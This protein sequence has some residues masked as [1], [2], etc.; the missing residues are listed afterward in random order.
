MP[1]Q[2]RNL[3]IYARKRHGYS[4]PPNATIRY[5][6]AA[7]DEFPSDRSFINSLQAP[8]RVAVG[9]IKGIY[10]AGEVEDSLGV[11]LVEEFRISDENDDHYSMPILTR[12]GQLTVV[13][14]KVSFDRD[15]QLGS[16]K[17]CSPSFL[18]STHNTTAST[19]SAKRWKHPLARVVTS[20]LEC[21]RPFRIPTM[22]VT[23]ST[24]TL[25][26]M[27]AFFEKLCLGISR[28]KNIFTLI[29]GSSMTNW[30]L[31]YASQALRNVLKLLPKRKLLGQKTRRGLDRLYA[32]RTVH[33]S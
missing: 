31:G 7:I 3:E 28:S 9:Q 12:T 29:A 17:V 24:F 1:G 4:I 21:A 33:C 10:V 20:L 23:S 25:S 5:V 2:H 22:A 11:T 19:G 26:T 13:A 14:S 32:G 16:L 27:P 6:C 8:T 15:F 18:Y 30:Q